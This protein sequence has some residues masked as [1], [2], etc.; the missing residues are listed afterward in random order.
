MLDS[1]ILFLNSKRYFKRTTHKNIQIFS[2]S[3]FFFLS[4]LPP[5]PH[6]PQATIKHVIH[7]CTSGGVYVPCIYSHA[8][9][10]DRWVKNWPNRNLFLSEVRSE[11]MK[12]IK[13]LGRQGSN[14]HLNCV[15]VRSWRSGLGIRAIL[16]IPYKNKTNK[17][18]KQKN[19]KTK[20]NLIPGGTS[21]HPHL[22][23]NIIIIY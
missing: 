11:R 1:F 22:Q 15:T 13:L 21:W 20:K 10:A 14:L 3:I 19:K 8:P 4:P 9:G 6:S 16:K 23:Y 2:A 18:Q 12:E 7:G 5:P 17:K